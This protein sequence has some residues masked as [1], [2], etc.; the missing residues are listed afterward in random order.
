MIYIYTNINGFCHDTI[1]STQGGWYTKYMWTTKRRVANR[2]ELRVPHGAP[3]K[4]VLITHNDGI[5]Q[6]MLLGV[7][8]IAI[9]HTAIHSKH[10]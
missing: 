5:M 6:S 7:T 4:S 2:N 10:S 1:P 8:L 3:L 9:K